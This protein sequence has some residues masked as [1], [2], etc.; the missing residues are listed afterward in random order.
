MNDITRIM[1]DYPILGW[2]YAEASDSLNKKISAEEYDRFM[3]AY[4]FVDFCK[5]NE[6]NYA[7]CVNGMTVFNSTQPPDMV[8]HVVKGSRVIGMVLSNNTEASV[9]WRLKH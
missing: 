6:Y 8:L 3:E 2:Y 1:Y 4:P 7:I 5:D 9:L